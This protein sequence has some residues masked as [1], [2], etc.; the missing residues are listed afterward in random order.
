MIIVQ[1]EKGTTTAVVHLQRNCRYI[2]KESVVE[3]RIHGQKVCKVCS[4]G[5]PHTG[6]ARRTPAQQGHNN[7]QYPTA[8]NRTNTTQS[9]DH[10]TNQLQNMDLNMNGTVTL[11]ASVTTTSPAQTARTLHALS[12]TGADVSVTLTT[13]PTE[14]A[15]MKQTH[16]CI[17]C[18]IMMPV[19]G[20]YAEMLGTIVHSDVTVRQ[21]GSTVPY[22]SYA[23]L[24]Y[25]KIEVRYL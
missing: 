6:S 16:T 11:N 2:R 22:G 9:V 13:R 21:Y 17:M 23:Y 1:K 8:R 12:A 20:N 15:T 24:T 5:I 14:D 18:P 3:V 10:I 7:R 25:R 4:E 19:K